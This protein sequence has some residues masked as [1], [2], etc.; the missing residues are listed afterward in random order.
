MSKQQRLKTSG[1]CMF[2][3][4][5]LLEATEQQR[6]LAEGILGVVGALIQ[7]GYIL[8]DMLDCERAAFACCCSNSINLVDACVHVGPEER[9]GCCLHCE[10]QHRNCY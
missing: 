5:A 7:A 10:E 9:S 2:S 1:M 3:D 6:K 8:N 4:V